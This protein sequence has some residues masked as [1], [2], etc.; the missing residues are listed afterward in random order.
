MRAS[1]RWPA[2]PTACPGWTRAKWTRSPAGCWRARRTKATLPLTAAQRRQVQDWE[3]FLN[4]PSP[5]ERL[6]SRYIYEH[7]FLGHLQ[8]EGD[9]AHRAF[10]L[11]R[12]STP[13]GQPLQIIASRR[14][15]DDPGVAR[16]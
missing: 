7:L 6:M 9:A 1:R 13:P 4:G 5:K 14:P 3:A 16:V 11:V 10:R 8:F 15:Y 2:C 12:S